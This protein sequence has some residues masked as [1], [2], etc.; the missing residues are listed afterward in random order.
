M[1]GWVFVGGWVFAWYPTGHVVSWLAF[2]KK[3]IL[4]SIACFITCG[5]MVGFL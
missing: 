4:H 5:I 1:G 3:P 2:Y